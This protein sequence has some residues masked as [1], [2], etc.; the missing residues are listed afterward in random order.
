MFIVVSTVLF[1]SI[2]TMARTTLVTPINGAKRANE[3]RL[4]RTTL[5]SACK[6]LLVLGGPGKPAEPTWMQSF[7]KARG[8]TTN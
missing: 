2:I 8:C 5:G 7:G 4:N 1:K 3:N 6:Q